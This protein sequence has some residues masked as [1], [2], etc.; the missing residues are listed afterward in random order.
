MV[1]RLKYLWKYYLQPV[2]KGTDPNS[3]DGIKL[4]MSKLQKDNT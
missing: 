1:N 2:L 3:E 4:R